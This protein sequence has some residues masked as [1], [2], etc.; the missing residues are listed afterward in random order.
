MKSCCGISIILGLK[1]GRREGEGGRE[2]SS[3]FDLFMGLESSWGEGGKGSSSGNFLF[4]G[5]DSC[6]GACLAVGRPPTAAS[7]AQAQMK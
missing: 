4:L 2:L 6:W 7:V 1:V 3:D 5:L